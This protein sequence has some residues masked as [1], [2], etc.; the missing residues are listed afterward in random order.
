M[1][2]SKRGLGVPAVKR[3]TVDPLSVDDW[4]VLVSLSL[5]PA[6][7]EFQYQNC[8]FMFHR[9]STFDFLFKKK[10]KKREYFD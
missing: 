1:G 5:L 8:Y 9:K 2:E 10:T 7:K 3:V 6:G 4:E